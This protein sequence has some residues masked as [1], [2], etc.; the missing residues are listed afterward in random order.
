M[1]PKNEPT[2]EAFAQT[3]RDGYRLT[4]PSVPLGA[5]M[6]EGTVHSDLPLAASLGQL[7]G[8]LIGAQMGVLLGF[9]ARRVL[10][11][12]DLSLLSPDPQVRGSLY[13]VEP[14]IAR[15]QNQLGL[16]D[17][18]FAHRLRAGDPAVLGRLRDGKLVLD[19]RTVFPEQIEMLTAAVSRC[20][21][22]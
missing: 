5:A 6:R 3:I 16:S 13:F 8:T 11:Q 10:G 20:T 17:E 21:A 4:R 9:L 2:P 12:Y 14:N 15:V 22:G 18:D 1:T 7:N 19:V